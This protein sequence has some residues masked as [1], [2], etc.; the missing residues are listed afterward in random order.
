MA[1][2]EALIV[3]VRQ[4]PPASKM[5]SPDDGSQESEASEPEKGQAG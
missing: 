5:T 2:L 1:R 4:D 3:A